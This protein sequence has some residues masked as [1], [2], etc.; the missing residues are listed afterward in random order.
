MIYGTHSK[1]VWTLMVSHGWNCDQQVW[2]R[3]QVYFATMHCKEHGMR[4]KKTSPNCS[5]K[6]R[7]GVT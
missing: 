6:Q 7:F 3:S 5:E 4:G 1:K 2:R